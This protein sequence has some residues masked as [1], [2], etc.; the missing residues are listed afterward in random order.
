MNTSSRLNRT[1]LFISC[2]IVFI[3]VIYT[4]IY[5]LGFPLENYQVIALTLF[6]MLC[7]IAVFS[8]AHFCILLLNLIKRKVKW[9]ELSLFSFLLLLI[10]LVFVVLLIVFL[11]ML[12]ATPDFSGVTF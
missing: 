10:V 6:V 11:L 4:V 3:S 7:L 5:S 8:I 12:A 1:S 2:C 9:K